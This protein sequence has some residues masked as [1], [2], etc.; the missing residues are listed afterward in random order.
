MRVSTE[1]VYRR[2]LSGLHG[3]FAK[4]VRSQEQVASGLR[5]LRP[6]DDPTGTARV[7]SLERQLSDSER[8]RDAISGGLTFV[9]AAA[10]ALEEG[11]QLIAEVRSL[12]LQGMNGTITADDRAA[13][14]QQVELLRTQLVEIANQRAADRYLFGG[15]KTSTPPWSFAAGG[16]VVY[17]GDV[18]LQEIRIGQGVTIPINV[19]GSEIFAKHQPSGLGFS[20]PT[21][22]AAGATASEGHGQSSIEVRQED[23]DASAL[24][25]GGL[26]I[27]AGTESTIVGSHTLVIDAVAGTARLGDGPVVDL[28]AVGSPSAA[29]FELETAAGAKVAFDLTGWNGADFTGTLTATASLRIG[30]GPWQPLDPSLGDL[31]LED[32]DSGNVLHVDLGGVGRTGRELV[33]FGG[34]IDIFALLDGIAQ[35]LKNADGV[36]QAALL[37]RLDLRIGELDRHHGNL[38]SALGVLGARSS[39]MS[40]TSSRFEA[41][42]VQVASLISEQRDA[43][44]TEVVL[45]MQRAESTLQLAQ[46]TGTRLIQRSLLDFL[47]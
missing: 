41:V 7:L 45:D 39:R 28:P 2:V 35:D 44:Y 25:A 23:L 32:P 27:A 20:G 29:S 36:D 19:P 16:K 43:D 8:I 24:A 1:S 4:L 21:G 31:R 17:G 13:L 15:T 38:L 40:T 9:D 37:G 14:G 46:A 6:S 26:A 42:G 22:L 34:Q 30:S 3:N 12:V 10:A 11:S 47:R 18:A 5:I 33:Q